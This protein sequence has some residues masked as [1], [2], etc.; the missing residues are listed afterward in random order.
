MTIKKILELIARKTNSTI[1]IETSL[2]REISKFV[3]LWGV[4]ESRFYPASNGNPCT[5]IAMIGRVR[6]NAFSET[7]FEPYFNRFK[8]RYLNGNE[9][10]RKFKSLY[11]N[12]HP[13]RTYNDF[14][15]I[16]WAR[17]N[18]GSAP[19]SVEFSETVLAIINRLR[20]NLFHGRKDF[21]N[22]NL[23]LEPLKIA[24]DCLYDV[25]EKNRFLF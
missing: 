2:G 14:E 18:N 11:L 19:D 23:E 15:T 5:Q 4:Y 3:L 25:I 8:K 9:G 10:E 22:L 16:L 24:N 21:A 7:D 20:N 1:T 12:E 6:E 13:P 17:L